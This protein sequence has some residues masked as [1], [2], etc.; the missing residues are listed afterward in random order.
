MA[1]CLFGRGEE[2]G[3]RRLL[4]T[5][6]EQRLLAPT[7]R[8]CPPWSESTGQPPRRAERPSPPRLGRLLLRSETGATSGIAC[9]M[10]YNLVIS[11]RMR[12][13]SGLPRRIQ[14]NSLNPGPRWIPAR[15]GPTGT[16]L[17]PGRAGRCQAPA[18]SCGPST[19]FHPV[20]SSHWDY[21]TSECS[22]QFVGGGLEH[23]VG[24]G[25]VPDLARS[26]R[27]RTAT[28]SSGTHPLG[29]SPQ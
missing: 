7:R 29:A 10:R 5:E 17:T 18:R 16:H 21:P 28:R 13:G 14:S 4:G 26:P 19:G 24:G 22:P 8:R 23:R 2:L 27:S 20:P 15:V 9:C 1:G 6:E 3:Y 11:L 12:S 25:E